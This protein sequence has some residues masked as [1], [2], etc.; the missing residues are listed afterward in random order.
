MDWKSIIKYLQQ[1]KYLWIIV[2]FFLFTFFYYMKEI[3]FLNQ[4]CNVFNENQIEQMRNWFEKYLIIKYLASIGLILF[5]LFISFFIYISYRY[6]ETPWIKKYG[7]FILLLSVFFILNGNLIIVILNSRE[8]RQWN[9]HISSQICY[10]ISIFFFYTVLFYYFVYHMIQCQYEKS[11]IPNEMYIALFILLYVSI[12]NFTL[13][14][15]QKDFMIKMFEKNKYNFLM[16]NCF[17]KDRIK[18]KFQ[19]ESIG[20]DDPTLQI[21]QILDEKGSDYLIVENEVPVQFMNPVQKKY[22]PLIVADFY[23]P[24]SYYTYLEDSPHQGHPSYESIELALKNYKVRFIHFDIFPSKNNPNIPVVRCKNM[25]KDGEE[26]SFENCLKI[27]QKHGWDIKQKYPV[28]LYLHFDE[29]A[30]VP[31]IYDFIYIQ[32]KKIFSKHMMNKK[33]SFSGRNGT[34]P[35]SKAPI[36]DCLKKMIL[37]TN[38]Y[39]TRSSLDE[40]IQVG[41]INRRDMNIQFN[42]DLYKESYVQ[43]DSMGIST[44]KDKTKLLE[45]HRLN[46][47][48]YYTEI[49]ENY[50]QEN[51]NKSG[52]YNPNFQDVAQYG[53]QGTCMYLFVPDTNLNNWYM[54][55]KSKNNMYPVLKDES[56][57]QLELIPKNIQE[58]NPIMALDKPQKYCIIPGFMETEKSNITDG[59][60]NNSCEV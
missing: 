37:C 21:K 11:M 22:Q 8:L 45:D 27:I 9:K 52:L 43:F 54:F 60:E 14:I 13:S 17:R 34:N 55:F 56:L 39:P 40:L 33:Y 36:K 20:D 35:V 49:N 2:S 23:Y 29:S 42:I 15:Y 10:G 30:K 19:T 58:Q 1:S 57:L 24:G 38:Q 26:L 41:N 51:Q 31:S 48:F 28:F 6:S 44:D 47:S 46:I 59:I 16:L 12:L 32:M 25:A 7:T 50:I 18:E 3:S 4:S 53:I 5:Y